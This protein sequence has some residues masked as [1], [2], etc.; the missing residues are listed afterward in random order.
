MASW[1]EPHHLS[2]Y[3]KNGTGEAPTTKKQEG[4]RICPGWYN[5]WVSCTIFCG[6]VNWLQCRQAGR[7]NKQSIYQDV[8]VSAAV[9]Q[10]LVIFK[11]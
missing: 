2:T 3:N 1:F 6:E 5:W 7:A 9:N 8:Y 4:G 11:L 10:L